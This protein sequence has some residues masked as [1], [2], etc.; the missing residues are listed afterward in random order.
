ME[1]VSVDIGQSLPAMFKRLK[2]ERNQGKYKSCKNLQ[3]KARL[4]DSAADFGTCVYS[5]I[6]ALHCSEQA[7]QNC[8]SSRGL[9]ALRSS[10]GDRH[11]VYSPFFVFLFSFRFTV[12]FPPILV[13]VVPVPVL[14]PLFS[15][16]LCPWLSHVC[17]CFLVMS[18]SFF[19]LTCWFL[20][21][22]R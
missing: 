22:C 6:G 15:A 11:Q 2:G 16:L 4:C 21:F 18:L 12:F 1:L 20:G 8:S 5:C 3:V 10:R 13:F 19:I 14:S 9:W 7:L 17:L